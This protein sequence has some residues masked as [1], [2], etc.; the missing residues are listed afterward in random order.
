MKGL[1]RCGIQ[2]LKS[3]HQSR[4]F[5][6]SAGKWRLTSAKIHE[7]NL[8]KMNFTVRKSTVQAPL[9]GKN[10]FEGHLANSGL[11]LSVLTF[12]DRRG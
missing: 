11:V 2:E 3:T 5:I 7:Y 8:K 1:V 9:R 10:W 6:A 12:R 4:V